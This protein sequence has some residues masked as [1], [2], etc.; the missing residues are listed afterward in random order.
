MMLLEIVICKMSVSTD[1][2]F[3]KMLNL[4]LS[5]YGEELG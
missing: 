3:R 4:L 2:Q 1:E 5:I